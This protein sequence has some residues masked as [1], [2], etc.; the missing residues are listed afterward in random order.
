MKDIEAIKLNT[1]FILELTKDGSNNFTY[2]IVSTEPFEDE[3]QMGSA[4][5][6]LDENLTNNRIQGILAIGTFGSRRSILLV[7]K[8]GLEKPLQYELMIDMKGRGK[9]KKTSTNPLTPS[10]PSTEIWPYNIHSIKIVAF[11]EIDLEPITIP[12]PEI[13]STCIL[14]PELTVENGELLF[15]QHFKKVTSGLTEKLGFNLES[16][17]T[18][19]DSIKAEDVS[20]GH[21]YSL[22]EGIYPFF[23]NYKFGNPLQ[24]RR[25]ECPYFDGYSSYFYTKDKKQVKVAGYKWGEFKLSDWSSERVD[26]TELR[27][28]FE[29]KYKSIKDLV[30]EIL[31]EPLPLDKEPDSGRID[32]KWKSDDGISAYLFMFGSY[33]EISLF[34]YRD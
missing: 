24:Y 8:N 6:L 32:T 31:G 12:E 29:Q 18:F 13:D 15:K 33:N 20:L 11:K 25:I 1:K 17:L 5:K 26:R 22:G 19:E 16:M 34:V 3:L 14:N 9:Y 7:M 30:S 10:I 2:E 28:A 4:F 27:N 23:N 21:F